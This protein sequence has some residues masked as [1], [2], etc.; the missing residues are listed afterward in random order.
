MR[1]TLNSN[2]RTLIHKKIP[3]TEMTKALGSEPR[4]VRRRSSNAKWT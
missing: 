4:S 2:P 3:D 1:K